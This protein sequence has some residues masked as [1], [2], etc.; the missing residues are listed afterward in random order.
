MGPLGPQD[1][2]CAIYTIFDYDY[3]PVESDDTS[4]SEHVSQESAASNDDDDDQANVYTVDQPEKLEKAGITWSIHTNPTKGRIPA[5]NIM[6]KKSGSITNNLATNVVLHLIDQLPDNVKQGRTV[7]Y[8]RY[9][10]DIKLSEA[11]LDRKMT[12]IGVVDY[13]RAFLPNELKGKLEVENTW[14]YDEV[15]QITAKL[16]PS[17]SKLRE[18][19]HGNKI[20]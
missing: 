16:R 1:T 17:T 13:R 15:L 14:K 18:N 19:S 2:N 10:T 12:S 6:K 11:L 3:V 7:T 4:A 8:D 5:Y 9:F 20:K